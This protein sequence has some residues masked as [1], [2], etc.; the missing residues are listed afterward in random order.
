MPHKVTLIPGDGTGPEIAEATRRVIEATGV[1]IDWEVQD[2][3]RRRHGAS[4]ARR[5]PDHVL[6]SIRR[7]NVALK[8]P[9]TTPIGT[10][11][12]SVNVALRQELDLYACLR[13]C[14]YY[15][16]VRTRYPRRRPGHR[17]REHRGPVRRHRVRAGHRRDRRA[18]RRHRPSCRPK[19]SAPDS[20]ISIKPISDSAPGASSSTPSSTPARTAARR[21]RPS[22]RRTS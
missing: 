5:C 11:F 1:E 9:I 18:D 10:G 12:R 15:P 20:A 3:G 14:K 17:P 19:R 8:G 21:S 13:P 2:A 7:N 16:G 4:T 22:T 6:E